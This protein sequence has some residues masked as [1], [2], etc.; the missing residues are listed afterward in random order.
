MSILIKIKLS[1]FYE[2]QHLN[3]IKLCGTFSVTEFDNQYQEYKVNL[4]QSALCTPLLTAPKKI[5]NF[6]TLYGNT[7]YHL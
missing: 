1:I 7:L 6:T 4:Q 3:Q 2:Q 5:E